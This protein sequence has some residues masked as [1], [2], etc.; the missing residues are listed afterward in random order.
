MHLAT[1]CCCCCC[2]WQVKVCYK[3]LRKQLEGQLLDFDARGVASLLHAT[4]QLG[5]C[6]P[7]LRAQVRGW[8]NLPLPISWWIRRML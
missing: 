6:D 8:R 7:H 1:V 5:C 2:C 3:Q 4:A